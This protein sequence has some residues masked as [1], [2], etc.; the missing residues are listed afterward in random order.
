M[1]RVLF[2]VTQAIKVAQG[3]VRVTVHHVLSIDQAITVWVSIISSQKNIQ[4]ITKLII[5]KF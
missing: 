4:F 3:T 5:I 1:W 2:Q